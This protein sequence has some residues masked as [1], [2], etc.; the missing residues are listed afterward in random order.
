MVVVRDVP[1]RH[2]PRAVERL[3]R[4]RQRTAVLLPRD[5]RRGDTGIRVQRRSA[6]HVVLLRRGTRAL[7]RAVAV[8]R[9][10]ARVIQVLR[11][12]NGNFARLEGAVVV[13]RL[14][15]RVSAL[16][17]RCVGLVRGLRMVDGIRPRV[18]R[19]RN[20]RHDARVGEVGPMIARRGPPVLLD[21]RRFCARV[22]I[23]SRRHVRKRRGR[24]R[25]RVEG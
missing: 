4:R 14:L 25:G 12:E 6:R 20:V 15:G 21:R 18:A 22:E 23:H 9:D 10:D 24:I 8:R 17:H 19:R 5:R 2:L 7:H 11:L 13:A 3:G 1:V 16:R